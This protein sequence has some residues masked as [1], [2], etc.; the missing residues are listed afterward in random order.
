LAC[1]VK[2]MQQL[3]SI[4]APETIYRICKHLNVNSKDRTIKYQMKNLENKIRR[5][6]EYKYRYN[7]EFDQKR[8]KR[9]EDYQR[10]PD[11]LYEKKK[12]RV[13]ELE[14]FPAFNKL[15][16]ARKW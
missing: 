6:P 12:D 10:K 13:H 1:P 14:E 2:T 5:M 9:Y 11:E 8:L 4:T 7:K 3:L 16:D 15:T